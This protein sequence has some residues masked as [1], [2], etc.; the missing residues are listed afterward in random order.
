MASVLLFGAISFKRLG[1][2]LVPDV[3]FP[4]ISI[5]LSYEGA[6]P[7]VM[8]SEVV[9]IVEDAIMSIQ[10]IKQIFSNTGRGSAS[11]TAEFELSK[12]TDIAFQEVLAAVSRIQRRLPKGVDSPSISKSSP[13]DSPILWLALSS[14]KLEPLELMNFVRDRI[15][16]R[17]ST[18]EGVGEVQLSGYVEPEMQIL[19]DSKKLLEY[20]L[21]FGDIVNSI[22][23][24][25]TESPT[26]R[27]Q[28]PDKEY[29]IR[30]L[31]ELESQLAFA[32]LPIASRGGSI[33]YSTI[34]LSDLS[35]VEEGLGEIRRKSRSDGV[36]AIG[37]GIKKQRGANA[38]AVAKAVK[39]KLK[40]ISAELPEGTT[41]SVRNDST[42]FIEEA[43]SELNFTLL[44][45]AI[46]TAFICWL[47]LGSWTSTLNIILS[48]PFSIVGSFS[49]LWA[50]GF[51]LN[52]FTLLGLSLA[53]GIVVDDAIMVLENIFRHNEMG[54]DKVTAAR[55]GV[56]EITFAALAATASIIAIFLP[57]AFIEGMIG[58]FLF[59]F[60]VTLSVAVA[61]SLIEALTLTPMRCAQFLDTTPRNTRIG[62]SVE[63]F[64]SWTQTVYK[65]LL[66]KVLINP[67]KVMAASL[68]FFVSSLGLLKILKFEFAPKEDQ[69]R[70]FIRVMAPEGSTLA[71]TDRKISNL[72]KYLLER[73][74]V[75]KVYTSL[76]GMGNTGATNSGFLFVTLKEKS[77]RTPWPELNNKKPK[78]SD[79]ADFYRKELRKIDPTL[80]AFVQ[81]MS[82]NGFGGGAGRGGAISFSIRGPD[83]SK[84]G[85]YSESIKKELEKTNHFADVDSNFQLGLPEYNVIPDREKARLRG[86][87]ISEIDQTVS[88]LFGGVLVGKYSSHGRRNEIRLRLRP[89]DRNSI[90]SLN[91]LFVRNN[92]GELVALKDVTTVI[93]KPA[94]QAIFRT[95]RERSI[96][97]SATNAQGISIQEATIEAEKIAQSILPKDYRIVWS[98]STKDTQ[99]S[100]QGILYALLLGVAIAYMIL[101]SQFNSFLDPISVLVALPFSV[102]GAFISLWIFDQTMNIYSMIGLI[103]LMGI[104]KKNSILLVDYTNQ[105]IETCPN[106]SVPEALKTACPVRLRPILMT[107]ISTLCG[108]LPAAISFGPGSES[109]IP[110]AI[111]I[112]GGVSVSTILTLFVVPPVYLLLSR[113]KPKSVMGGQV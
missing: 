73:P 101:G 100:T 103:L 9:D 2:G 48:I 54:K 90:E 46:L 13:D 18:I 89:E 24:E 97:M 102:S 108:A 72:E 31:G 6:S 28:T 60:G 7:E 36:P 76:G 75:E 77:E 80:K 96:N 112:I 84:M 57:I 40:E 62:R 64:F 11:V 94:L 69:S 82:F 15:K 88:A 51:T 113:F 91:S 3:D 33:N 79:I 20:Q 95:D 44:A 70:L 4:N 39:V 26:G 78:Q 98:G 25:H 22:N 67:W 74:E 81:E 109:R 93:Q 55:D 27:I 50:L 61:F 8:E 99:E 42:Q 10:G 107:T 41:L 52:T 58:R 105:V 43:V 5:S 23:K 56:R 29:S 47:F 59:Q 12:N 111:S 71:V 49:V 63:S 16:D 66:P 21:S 104:V 34:K 87:S 85:E 1:V 30:T 65:N 83:W 37:F 17:F 45:A 19:L 14:T 35:K 68:L 86:V 53:I 110:M 32:N 106:L 92:R 38:V